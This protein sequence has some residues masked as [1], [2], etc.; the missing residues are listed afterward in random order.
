MCRN[1]KQICHDLH[2][3]NREREIS[4]LTEACMHLN[5][6]EGFMLT[7]N[8]E[9]EIHVNDVRITVIPV[10]RWLLQ[11]QRVAGVIKKTKK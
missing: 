8:E 6:R 1:F 10:W 2:E 11:P 9:D 5:V 7:G 4:G 3:G